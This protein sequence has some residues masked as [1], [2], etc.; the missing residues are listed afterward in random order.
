MSFPAVFSL[1]KAGLETHGLKG[2]ALI[3]PL[4]TS[5]NAFAEPPPQDKASWGLLGAVITQQRPYKGIDRDT[6]AFPF[7][8]YENKYIRVFGPFADLKLPSLELSD[9][10]KIDFSIV[11]Q[12]EFGGYNKDDTKDTWILRGMSGRKGGFWA[13]PK[14]EWHTELFDISAEWLAD[15]S[16]NS[17]GYRFNIGLEKSW[18]FGQHMMLTPRV[19]AKWQ[20]KKFVDYYY[21]VRDEEVRYDRAAYRGDSATNIDFGIRGTYMFNQRHSMFLDLEVTSLADEIK[22]SPLVDRSTQNFVLFAYMYRF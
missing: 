1:K 13:G 5:S 15:V 4:L 6:M 16:A 18:R 11:G 9:T 3:F 17:K 20:D 12:F 22:D 19:V 8:Y 21:G 7:I 2:L 14:A 10:Q